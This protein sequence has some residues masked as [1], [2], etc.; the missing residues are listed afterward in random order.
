LMGDASDN[1]KGVKGIGEKTALKLLQQYN[2]LEGIYEHIDELSNSTKNKLI[3]D[4]QSAFDSK[5]LATIYC[6][7]ELNLE[8]EDIRYQKEKTDELIEIYND[9]EFYSF[10]KK[11]KKETKKEQTINYT[12][13]NNIEDIKIN[14]PVA[15]YLE[16]DKSNYHNAS[17][18]GMGVYNNEVSYY[19]PEC[20]LKQNPSFLTN[21]KLYTY[22]YKKV[23]V[24]F[25]YD[26]I[27]IDNVCFDTM[28]VSY[29]TNY[30][31]KEDIDSLAIQFG[32]N[33]SNDSIE[34]SCVQKAKFIYETKELLEDKMKK[35]EVYDFY[36]NIEFP[37]SIVLANMELNGIRVDKEV[38]TNMGAEL[39]NK[40]EEVSKNIYNLVG[41]EFNIASPRQLG[42]ILFEKLNLPFG[43][44]GKSGYYTTDVNVLNKLKY[45]YPIAQLVLEYRSLTKLKSTY[46][47]GMLDLVQP[48]GKIHT[49]YTQAIARTGRLSSIEPNLQ[50]IPARSEY[51]RLIRKAFIAEANSCILSSDYSQIE[52]RI[53]AHLSQAKELIE[54]FNTN[55]DI[56][57]KTA[58]D[59]FQVSKDNVT[60]EMRRHA[61]AVNFGI[62]YGISSFGLS[63]ELEINPNDAKKFIEA[64]FMTY[65]S[66]KDYMI[67]VIDK[68]HKDGYV[69]TLMN[70]KRIID[71][72]NNKNKVIKKM[73]ERMALNTPIQGSSADII[74]KAMIEIHNKF[75]EHNLKSTMLLQ[76]H[77]ELIFN[78]IN[79]EKDIVTKI[80]RE[81]MENTYKLSVPLKVD[82]EYGNNWYEAK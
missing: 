78:C 80:V 33:F 69:K 40:I 27:K 32:Y 37:L 23:Y 63:E 56:H 24:K 81:V 70:R 12:L 10:L 4:K 64:Y 47:D 71:E 59:I 67:E 43:K 58:M 44:K 29:L 18:I 28:L 13:V 65:S 57:T 49:I 41:E 35:E 31:V 3:E 39:A 15:I 17:I 79:E 11:V 45:D 26:N 66:I 6:D 60:K 54:A 1:I 82:I 30:N 68:A 74:K 52:L 8:F 77:D 72:I 5:E 46:V 61:K 73:G 7:V 19:I 51:G 14:G 38:L 76:V 34:T 9:L 50:N 36:Q 16:L 2:S 20:L 21:T 48:D 75:I 42:E 55:M 53:F 22:D 62:L 25:K